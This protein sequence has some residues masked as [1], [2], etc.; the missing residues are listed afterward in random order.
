[1]G[2]DDGGGGGGDD[3][4]CLYNSLRQTEAIPGKFLYLPNDLDI[5]AYSSCVTLPPKIIGYICL[6]FLFAPGNTSSG[7]HISCFSLRTFPE[8]CY[9]TSRKAAINLTLCQFLKT[10]IPM[11][12]ETR[13][14]YSSIPGT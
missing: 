14:I 12:I 10:S 9:P 4:C 11:P 13:A 3:V 2:D 8:G 1:M 6:F 5:F 7:P